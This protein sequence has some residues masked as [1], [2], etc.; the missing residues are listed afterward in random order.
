M[1]R[2]D[3]YPAIRCTANTSAPSAITHKLAACRRSWMRNR[4]T[5]SLPPMFGHGK[6]L[7]GSC[8]ERHGERRHADGPIEV[9]QLHHPF[10]DRG[11]SRE[12][13]FGVS[14]RIRARQRV[15]SFTLHWMM[16]PTV[17]P[18]HLVDPGRGDGHQPDHW[19]IPAVQP[20]LSTAILATTMR[21]VGEQLHPLR[22]QVLRL[23]GLLCW[24]GQIDARRLIDESAAHRDRNCTARALGRLVVR[25]GGRSWL[26]IEPF[27]YGLMIHIGDRRG[28][29][30]C[31]NG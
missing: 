3:L 27:L 11:I 20:A 25:P 9:E 29:P 17:S 1:V 28:V 26:V 15:L 13:P 22:A 8:G 21:I 23:V 14:D 24:H 18:G 2:A 7:C 6:C 10:G 5:A 12:S 31:P 19:P 30:S 16:E 4:A